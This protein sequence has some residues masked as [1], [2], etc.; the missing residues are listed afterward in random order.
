MTNLELRRHKDATPIEL[1]RVDHEFARPAQLTT[2]R[3]AA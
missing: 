3:S 1:A 2:E